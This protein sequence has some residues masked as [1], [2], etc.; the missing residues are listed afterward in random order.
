MT[1][2]FVSQ[3]AISQKQ[4]FY[5]GTRLRKQSKFNPFLSTMF[6]SAS[7]FTESHLHPLQNLRLSG[8]HVHRKD[9][10]Y[11]FRELVI[12]ILIN[13]KHNAVALPAFADGVLENLAVNISIS[14]AWSCLLHNHNQCRNVSL[15]QSSLIIMLSFVHKVL[16]VGI[17]MLTVDIGYH[18]KTLETQLA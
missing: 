9:C 14:S 6:P 10:L 13:V 15:Y 11:G 4:D 16:S 1:V 8:Y 18:I 17:L 5:I 7:C 12:F 3:Q 2:R